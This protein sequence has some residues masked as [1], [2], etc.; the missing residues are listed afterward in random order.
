MNTIEITYEVN[1]SD[2]ETETTYLEVEYEVIRQQTDC[3]VMRDYC[4]I[5]GVEFLDTWLEDNIY[6]TADIEANQDKIQ[7]LVE[8]EVL[9]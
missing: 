5:K 1:V 9:K 2:D 8:Q 7:E 4:E 3:G 6:A